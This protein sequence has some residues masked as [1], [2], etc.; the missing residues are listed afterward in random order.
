MDTPHNHSN[1]KRTITDPPWAESFDLFWKVWPKIRR[2]AKVYAVKAWKKLKPDDTLV[3]TIL[4]DVEAKA[5]TNDW[6]KEGGRFIP[7]PATYLNGRR[8]EDES[9]ATGE[10]EPTYRG[11]DAP[12]S[13]EEVARQAQIRQDVFGAPR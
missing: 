9:G 8:W 12:L 3:D 7:L 4:A 11:I 2:K 5:K 13:A 10:G 1:H 6:M